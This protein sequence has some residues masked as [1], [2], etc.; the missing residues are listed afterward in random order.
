MSL[1]AANVNEPKCKECL[2]ALPDDAVK[3]KSCGAYQDWTRYLFRW[4]TVAGAILTVL[5]L[6]GIVIALYGGVPEIKTANL[7]CGRLSAS[8]DV[9]NEGDAFATVTKARLTPH[10]AAG[11]PRDLAVTG[12]KRILGKHDNTTLTLADGSPPRPICQGCKN[13]AF[14]VTLH[15]T[16]FDG[17]A[18]KTPGRRCTCPGGS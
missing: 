9:F 11:K 17:S 6:W 13:C 18:D 8:I 10:G 3:C 5:P 4:S 16:D 7:V 1:N 15:F 14:T 2:A 12:G